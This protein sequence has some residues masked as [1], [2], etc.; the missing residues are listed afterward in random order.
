MIITN[1]IFY[2]VLMRPI[3]NNL[4]RTGPSVNLKLRIIIS[5]PTKKQEDNVKNCAVANDIGYS[6]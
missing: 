6:V 5:K 3:Q 1:Y 2:V 4:F